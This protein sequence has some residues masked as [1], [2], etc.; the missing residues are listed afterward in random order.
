D[1]ILYDEPTV[2]ARFGFGPELL[3]D[4]KGLRG[5]PSDNII[6]ITGI[7]EKTATDLITNF[8][9]LEKMYLKLKK[10]DEAFLQAG[11]KARMIELLKAGEEEALFSK[12][13]ALIRRDVPIEFKLSEQTWAEGFQVPAVEKL[14]LS[15]E[16]KS[17]LAR[18]KNFS[19]SLGRKKG[20]DEVEE[21]RWRS[22]K[23][24]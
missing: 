19:Q 13:L 1:T 23:S 10:G 15:L 11:I 24:A 12:T 18:V 20:E 7:G 6:G 5:D 4:Y 2:R 8:G 9:S 21:A 3:P 22:A 17:L 16:F 14:F